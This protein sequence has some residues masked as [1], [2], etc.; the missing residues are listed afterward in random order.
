LKKSLNSD[1]VIETQP[2]NPSSSSFN[3]A[4]HH[5]IASTNLTFSPLV[6]SN[7][8]HS[9]TEERG[10]AFNASYVPSLSFV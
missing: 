9:S 10:S 6:I 5:A 2:S 8:V 7:V 4:P 3:V 1:F